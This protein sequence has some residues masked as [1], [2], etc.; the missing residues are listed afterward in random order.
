[1]PVPAAFFASVLIVIVI[2]VVIMVPMLP[3]A[4]PPAVT[5]IRPDEIDG[6]AAGV[7]TTAASLPVFSIFVR[8][9]HIDR[10]GAIDGG[11]HNDGLGIEN[12]RRWIGANRDLPKNT[13][14]EFAANG[15]VHIGLRM[16]NAG[17]Q[18]GQTRQRQREKTPRAAPGRGADMFMALMASSVH[19]VSPG[20]IR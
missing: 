17:Q 6:P 18:E 1:M 10:L 13:G 14:N 20:D 8:D 15:D 11:T 2:V 12:R 16:R 9:V 4:F 19:L 5:L 7:V 3:T